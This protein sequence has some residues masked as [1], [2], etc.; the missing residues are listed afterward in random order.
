MIKIIGYSIAIILAML[1]PIIVAKISDN[2]Q[3]K[4]ELDKKIKEEK[5]DLII[6]SYWNTIKERRKD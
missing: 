6:V 5:K 2:Q 1:I 4:W 3:R